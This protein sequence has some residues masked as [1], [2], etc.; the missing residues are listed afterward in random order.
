MF[1]RAAY[2]VDVDV[3]L[4]DVLREF[5]EGRSHIAVVRRAVQDPGGGDPYY[6]HIGIITLEDV[7]EEILQVGLPMS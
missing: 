4:L 5:K 3:T 2:A 7:I 1:G 6:C